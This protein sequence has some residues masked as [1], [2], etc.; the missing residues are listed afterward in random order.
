MYI[1]KYI[2]IDVFNTSRT[3]FLKKEDFGL[4]VKAFGSEFTGHGIEPQWHQVISLSNPN[5]MR[6]E[7]NVVSEQVRHKLSCTSTEDG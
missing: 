2:M 6:H 3:F 7:K 5:E 4:V 1:L